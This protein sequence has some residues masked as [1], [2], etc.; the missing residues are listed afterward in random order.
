MFTSTF[1]ELV[2]YFLAL[3]YLVIGIHQGLC[4]V[5]EAMCNGINGI[6]GGTG[7]LLGSRSHYVR[8]KMR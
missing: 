1:E 6:R 5:F 7:V 2:T 4:R 8:L 3:E